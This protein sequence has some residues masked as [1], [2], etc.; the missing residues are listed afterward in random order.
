MIQIIRKRI[1]CHFRSDIFGLFELLLLIRRKSGL[2]LNER[3]RNIPNYI[4]K[5]LWNIKIPK[6]TTV[7]ISTFPNFK[8]N[9]YKFTR[10][11][12]GKANSF[13][14]QPVIYSLTFTCRQA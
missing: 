14:F 6:D 11:Q 7:F 5:I 12:D 3:I 8:E 4:D 2:S 9:K 10:Y 13:H 1:L